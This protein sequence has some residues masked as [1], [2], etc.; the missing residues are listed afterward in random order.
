MRAWTLRS[1]FALVLAGSLLTKGRATDVFFDSVDLA[2][3]VIRVARSQGLVF[4]GYTI[5]PNTDVRALAF[6]AFDCPR[7][8][9]VVLL[10]V[11]FDQDPTVRSALE[12]RF[13]PRYVYI[14]S[15]WDQPRRL[16]VFVKRMKYSAL[17]VFGL[18]RYAPS[19]DVLLIE[20]PPQ[21]HVADAIDW[22]NVWNLDY[23]RA[24]EDGKETT[25]Q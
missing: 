9:L 8:L 14:D 11:T 3:A 19:R 18:T 6:E 1:V 25:E 21:C 5:V 22:R 4:R 10:S 17:A 7:L 16:A 23:L 12:S 2:P 13:A 20:S 24:A 15:T